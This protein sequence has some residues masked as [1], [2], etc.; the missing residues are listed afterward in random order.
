MTLLMLGTVA[1]VIHNKLYCQLA[2]ACFGFF[3][4]PILFVAFELAV[5]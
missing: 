4:V 1:L 2:F 3:I 5:D